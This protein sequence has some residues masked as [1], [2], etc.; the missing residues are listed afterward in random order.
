MVIIQRLIF[1]RKKPSIPQPNRQHSQQL[2][3]NSLKRDKQYPHQ[4]TKMKLRYFK[5][6]EM[7]RLSFLL[8]VEELKWPGQSMEG[9]LSKSL[10]TLQLNKNQHRRLSKL[11]KSS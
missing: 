5:I 6:V 10:L 11:N 8:R 9:Q 3:S 2:R 7:N 1:F 4:M